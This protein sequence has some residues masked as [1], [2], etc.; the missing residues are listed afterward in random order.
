[1]YYLL[2]F[3]Q[4]VRFGAHLKGSVLTAFVHSCLNKTWVQSYTFFHTNNFL[5]INYLPLVQALKATESKA[6]SVNYKLFEDS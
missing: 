5:T 4:G 2:L 3:P 6:Q 1:M